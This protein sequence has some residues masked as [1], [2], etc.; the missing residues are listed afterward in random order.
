M[1]IFELNYWQVML[2]TGTGGKD[3]V[4]DQVFQLSEMAE[5]LVM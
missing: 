1:Q 4:E 3:E 2:L 5:M